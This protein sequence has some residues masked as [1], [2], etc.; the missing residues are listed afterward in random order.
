MKSRVLITCPQ[1]QVTVDQYRQIFEDHDIEIELP[2]IDQHLREHELLELI[3]RV[4]GIIAGDDEL[5]AKV[6]EK[7]TQLKVIARW[8]VGVDGVDLETAEQLGIQVSN[9]PG[10]FSDE[11]ADVVI[12][13]IIMLARQLHKLDQSIRNGG[14]AK[15][16]GITLRGKTLGIIGV[17][18]I[19]RAVANRGVACGMQ[20]IG[21]DLHP[22]PDSVI[23][24]VP[25]RMVELD[26]LLKSSDFI[27]LNCNLTAENRH[28]LG[29][30]QFEMMKPGVFIINAS[31]G[32]LIDEEALIQALYDR[33]ISG[34]ALDVFESEPLPTDSPLRKFENCIF[35]SHN[36]SNTFEAVMRVN[37]LAIRNLIAGL[38]QQGARHNL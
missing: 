27:S 31:R 13:Y 38:E 14:W 1:L 21:H 37:D 34:A 24:T 22:V 9:T 36:G 35:G 28:M 6:L 19:G 10:V 17:G 2:V 20:I 25:L 3:E 30:N 12:G 4:D 29:T 26:Q 11:V 16:P 18:S 5:S 7:A 8:G 32:A 23:E 15:I 33:K